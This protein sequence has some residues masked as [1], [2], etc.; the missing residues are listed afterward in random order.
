MIM[1]AVM[2]FVW[3]F[4][5]MLGFTTRFSDGMVNKNY[6]MIYYRGTKCLNMFENADY[7]LLDILLGL[8]RDS[9]SVSKNYDSC[10][11]MGAGRALV[12]DRNCEVPVI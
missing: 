3:C 7:P 2:S 10:V 9:Y 11:H 1:S 8:P 4:S 6:V 5:S 12:E